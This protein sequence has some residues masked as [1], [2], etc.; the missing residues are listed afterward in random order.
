VV[1][2]QKVVASRSRLIL[3]MKEGISNLE[4]NLNPTIKL[5]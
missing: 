1:T 5:G 3:Q 2:K 4:D